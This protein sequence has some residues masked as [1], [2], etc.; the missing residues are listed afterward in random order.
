MDASEKTLVVGPERQTD[1]PSIYLIKCNRSRR[2]TVRNRIFYRVDDRATVDKNAEQFNR[3]FVEKLFVE[4][5]S[6]QNGSFDS[7]YDEKLSAWISTIVCAKPIPIK[8]T[9]YCKETV[10][11]EFCWGNF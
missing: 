3:K 9:E 5:F 4:D 6:S 11:V 1:S 7:F 10:W 2:A 8:I